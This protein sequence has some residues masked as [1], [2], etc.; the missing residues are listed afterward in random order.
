MMD[1]IASE[2]EGGIEFKTY[3]ASDPS[4]SHALSEAA[5]AITRVID[6]HGIAVLTTSGY[7]ARLMAAERPKTP[8]FAL[9]PDAGIYHSLN[10][11]WGLKPLLIE[12][13]PETFEA[14]VQQAESALLKLQLVSPGNKILVVGGLPAG[15]ARGSNFIKIHA[16]R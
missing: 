2:V 11:F 9:T 4:D 8:L 3:P 12:G 1:R 7:T 16:V 6:L 13:I 14:L 10:L 5:T 15:E